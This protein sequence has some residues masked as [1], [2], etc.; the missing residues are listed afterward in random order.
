MTFV[1]L[2]WLDC[3]LSLLMYTRTLKRQT[4]EIIPPNRKIPSFRQYNFERGKCTLGKA[5]MDEDEERAKRK[6][7]FAHF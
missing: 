5:G 7:E 4:R 3:Y 2:L 6:V 1:I